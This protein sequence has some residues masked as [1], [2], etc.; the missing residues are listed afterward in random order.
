[1]SLHFFDYLESNQVDI[2]VMCL[3]IWI[4]AVFVLLQMSRRSS[5]GKEILTDVSSSPIAKRT[6]LSFQLSKDSNREGSKLL[7]IHRLTQAFF[8]M[9]LP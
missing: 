4:F 9:L 8:K 1:M 2:R 7:L 5:K 3:C 6:R